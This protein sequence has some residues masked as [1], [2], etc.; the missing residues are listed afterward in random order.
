[1]IKYYL[2]ILCVTFLTSQNSIK[3][4]S[5]YSMFPDSHRL[6][7]HNYG[8]KNYPFINHYNDSSVLV[9]LPKNFDQN[10]KFDLIVYFHGWNNS[11]ENATEEFQLVEQLNNSN[12]NA[13]LI[14]PEGP[15]NAPDSFG[16]KL[17]KAN[18][19][20]Y[21]IDD[22]VKQSKNYRLDLNS[23]NNIILAGHSGAYRV[24]ATILNRGGLTENISHVILFD[25]L[26]GQ[27]EKYSHWLK[28]YNGKFI[29]LITENGGTKKE[30]DEFLKNLDDWNISYFKSMSND[31]SKSQ[32]NN[33][34]IIFL[35][36]SLNHND[37]IN[38]YF[39]KILKDF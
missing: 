39:E 12:K 20:K 11:N 31:L 16:G 10:K 38:P 6:E 19:F 3:I 37:V 15:K 34:R 4:H 18:Y 2:L 14:F 28:N 30:S 29:N 8:E 24:I 36:T 7:G 35:Y 27:I 25:G 26:Y 23:Y 22:I 33:H 13:V 1:M 21:L 17:E 9:L 5:T 32:L